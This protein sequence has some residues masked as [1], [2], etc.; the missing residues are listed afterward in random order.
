MKRI[1]TLTITL[2]ALNAAAQ[3][4]IP[5]GANMPA[6]GFNAP[7]LLG[8]LPGG[9]GPAG[10]SLTWDFSPISFS[11]VGTLHVSQ[12]SGTPFASSFPSANHVLTLYPSVGSPSY[13]YFNVG[14]TQMEIQAYS[15]S[16]TG[17]STDYSMNPR[18][19]MKFP[20]AFNDSVT[21]LWQGGASAPAPV[22]VKYD[23]YGTLITPTSTY[24]NVVRIKETYSNGSDYQWYTTNPMANVMS[25]YH[26]SNSLFYFDINNSTAIGEAGKNAAMMLFPNPAENETTL[27]IGDLNT[28]VMLNVYDLTGKMV[29]QL[30]IVTTVTTID[31]SDMNAGMYFYSITRDNIVSKTGKLVV[32]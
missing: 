8:T 23:A 4:V 2:I 16:S 17:S 14:G 9:P 31:L 15:I 19:T 32:E 21:D 1:F 30:S 27:I 7:L 25:Y 20:M 18:T 26:Q 28:Q 13:S 3:P 29:K 24:N 22:T 11:R 5:N 10:A 6:V 12:P